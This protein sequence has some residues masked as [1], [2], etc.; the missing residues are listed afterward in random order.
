METYYGN[1]QRNS[2]LMRRDATGSKLRLQ[3]KFLMRSK[4]ERFIARIFFFCIS[5]GIQE[6]NPLKT[7]LA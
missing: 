2:Y 5:G 1:V 6:D 7:P 3:E 4:F